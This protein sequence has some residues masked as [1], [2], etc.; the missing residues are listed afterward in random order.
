MLKGAAAIAARR[1]VAS[2]LTD[3]AIAAL[4]RPFNPTKPESIQLMQQLYDAGIGQCPSSGMPGF[5]PSAC[6]REL[7]EALWAGYCG[8]ATSINTRVAGHTD[9]ALNEL[10]ERLAEH[11]AW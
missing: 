1:H 11:V 10:R 7:R 4:Q 6:S 2:R 3:D 9:A 5:N 8:A